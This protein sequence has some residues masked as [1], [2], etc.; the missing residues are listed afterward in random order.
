M[1]K[2][3]TES[4]TKEQR[5]AT[6]SVRAKARKALAVADADLPKDIQK[7]LKDVIAWADKLLAPAKKAKPK[8]QAKAKAA[9]KPDLKKAA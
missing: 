4:M 5:A 7:H 9:D 2:S 6:Q 8:A 1:S 3:N